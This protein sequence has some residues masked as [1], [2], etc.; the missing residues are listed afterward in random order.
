MRLLP[1]TRKS[2]TSALAKALP[3]VSATVPLSRLVSLAAERIFAGLV[4]PS[5]ID[6]AVIRCASRDL[7]TLDA[8]AFTDDAEVAEQRQIFLARHVELAR[9][10]IDGSRRREIELVAERVFEGFSHGARRLSKACR[11]SGGDV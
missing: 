8:L 1:Y 9:T 5:A 2:L 4:S 7:I 6:V 11:A 3:D 10:I